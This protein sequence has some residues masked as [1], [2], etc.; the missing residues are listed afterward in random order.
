MSISLLRIDDRLIHGQVVMTWI[1]H[2]QCTQIKIVDQKTA[3]DAFMCK[4]L[5]SIAPR[6]I[7]LEIMGVEKAVA[8]F[9]EWESS[10]EHVMVIVRTPM[11]LQ[12]MAAGG[13]KFKTINIGGIAI[14]ADRKKFHKNIA[15]T[16]EEHAFLLSQV[17]NGVDVYYQMIVSERRVPI[18]EKMFS[19]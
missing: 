8:A 3:D 12:E 9:Q 14:S 1:R 15:L 17:K 7:E 18:T 16:T 5:L 2:I 19:H 11:T 6:G 10:S 13:I 4:L